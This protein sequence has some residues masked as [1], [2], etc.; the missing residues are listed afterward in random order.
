[1]L[2]IAPSPADLELGRTFVALDP[3]GDPLRVVRPATA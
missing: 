2:R 1:M 3:D